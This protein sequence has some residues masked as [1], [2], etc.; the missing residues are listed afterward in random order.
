MLLKR[1][2]NTLQ[3]F[4]INRGGFLLYEA[5]LFGVKVICTPDL[6]NFLLDWICVGDATNPLSDSYGYTADYVAEPIDGLVD[7]L[8]NLLRCH[9]WSIS[10]YLILAPNPPICQLRLLSLRFL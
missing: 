9:I 10:K 7:Q 2:I 3:W 8:I 1:R 5:L 4:G 6:D